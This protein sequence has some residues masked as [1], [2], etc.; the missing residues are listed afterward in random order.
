MRGALGL[1]G[2]KYAWMVSIDFIGDLVKKYNSVK[3]SKGKDTFR[4]D[5]GSPFD[6]SSRPGPPK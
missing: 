2:T 6:C 4:L 1:D 3:Q 5:N